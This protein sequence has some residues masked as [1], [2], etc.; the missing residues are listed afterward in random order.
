MAR[1]WLT[2]NLSH[3]HSS[4]S[5][6][7]ASK[8]AEITRIGHH[9]WLLFLF[10]FLVEMWFHH[11]DQAG[12]E[13]LTSGLALLPRLEYS[14]LLQPPPPRLKQ[15]SHL[16]LQVA[17]TTGM[18]N[19][20]WLIFCIFFNPSTSASSVTGTTD[21]HHHVQP[22]FLFFVEMG[23]RY[24]VQASLKFLGSSKPILASQ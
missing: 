1:S 7:S 18:H 19:H 11:A 17:E 13:L 8:I 12:L 3:L 10:L 20:A 2:C 4:N 21:K 24:V 23:S 6:A 22:V 16:S 9:V 5:P 14:G 15:S